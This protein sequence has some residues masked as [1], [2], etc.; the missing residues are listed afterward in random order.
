VYLLHHTGGAQN[1]AI[2]YK[3]EISLSNQ[4]ADGDKSKTA[5][6]LLSY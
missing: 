4:I 6:F 1:T 3:K 2:K 5:V